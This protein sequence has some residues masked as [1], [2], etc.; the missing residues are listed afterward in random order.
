M[1]NRLNRI[2]TKCKIGLGPTWPRSYFCLFHKYVVI[3]T[4]EMN[5]FRHIQPNSVTTR[6]SLI[7]LRRLIWSKPNLKLFIKMKTN[8]LQTSI[9]TELHRDVYHCNSWLSDCQFTYCGSSSLVLLKT[10]LYFFLFPLF[11]HFFHFLPVFHFCSFVHCSIENNLL[12]AHLITLSLSWKS[13]TNALKP[14]TQAHTIINQYT[15]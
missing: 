11:W 6:S 8:I 13:V 9:G 12:N 1:Q 14:R 7:N 15:E 2:C 5:S 3:S 4:T 10:F